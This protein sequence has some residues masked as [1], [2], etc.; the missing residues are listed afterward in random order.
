MKKS[1]KTNSN[2]QNL[3][4]YNKCV[5]SVLKVYISIQKVEMMAIFYLINRTY[6]FKIY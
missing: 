3:Y 1:L 4:I 2:Y 6:F 5:I